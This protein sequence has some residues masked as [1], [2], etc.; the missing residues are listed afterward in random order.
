MPDTMKMKTPARVRGP[1]AR[2]G[3]AVPAKPTGNQYANWENAVGIHTEGER[4]KTVAESKMPETP[5]SMLL[6]FP[7]G[8]GVA[9]H[10]RRGS[11][12]Q[13][14]RSTRGD[15]VTLSN[16]ACPTSAGRVERRPRKKRRGRRAVLGPDLRRRKSRQKC[17]RMENHDE[18]RK[19]EHCEGQ[20]YRGIAP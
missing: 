8:S 10:P 18:N 19:D 16:R 2:H 5:V 9:A 13:H 6:P 17:R 12:P 11:P 7:G 4:C 14:A 1:R 20:Q 15:A 3:T